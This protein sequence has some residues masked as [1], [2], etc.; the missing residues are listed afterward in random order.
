MGIEGVRVTRP[1]GIGTSL[2]PNPLPMPNPSVYGYAG[3]CIC[4]SPCPA[5]LLAGW[6]VR[7]IWGYIWVYKGMWIAPTPTL[8]CCALCL[9]SPLWCIGA[10]VSACRG[11][12]RV[13]PLPLGREPYG[14]FSALYYRSYGA[15][16]RRG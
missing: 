3:M 8:P 9:I 11:Y 14:G 5:L 1:W 16:L 12:A 7:P 10:P 15:G 2:P 6:C 13:I 4:A